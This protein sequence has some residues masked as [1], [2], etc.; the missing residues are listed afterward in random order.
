VF[1]PWPKSSGFGERGH[2]D[3]Y[4]CA[5][6]KEREGRPVNTLR[7][8]ET[9]CEQI[10]AKDYGEVVANH[11]DDGSCEI[12]LPGASEQRVADVKNVIAS[13]NLLQFRIVALKS[14]DDKLI[15][16]CQDG[17]DHD[18]AVWAAYDPDKVEFP[19]GAAVRTTPKGKSMVLILEGNEPVDA[20]HVKYASEGRDESLRVSLLG[21]FDAEGARRMEKLTSTNLERQLAIIFDG[22][23]I[24]AP[25][26]VSTFGTHFQ[27]TGDFTV[28]QIQSLI[29][30]LRLARAFGGLESKPISVIKVAA[31]G[32]K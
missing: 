17:Q 30:S 32:E 3:I 5:G 20:F 16:A 8:S 10:N 24:S 2:Y 23:V 6:P 4:C 18:G 26:I 22:T 25:T 27:L 9:L 19:P 12:L 13:C 14:R 31:G 21:Q 11:L 7:I 28:N 29:A 1:H 15:A